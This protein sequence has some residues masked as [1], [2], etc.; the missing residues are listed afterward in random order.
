[1]THTLLSD[2]TRPANTLV[3][4][5]P[6]VDKSHPYHK[7]ISDLSRSLSS[8]LHCILPEEMAANI[9]ELKSCLS[10]YPGLA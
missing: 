10:S 4:L 2:K 8:P 1:M 6:L 3:A 7:L 9:G 5:P